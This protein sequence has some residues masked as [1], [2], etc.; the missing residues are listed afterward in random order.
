M[1]ELSAALQGRAVIIWGESRGILGGIK[2]FV[3][4]SRWKRCPMGK[5]H[6]VC[7]SEEILRKLEELTFIGNQGRRRK[8]HVLRILK[9]YF[10]I[11]SYFWWLS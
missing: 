6:W 5:A 11:D 1:A 7:V 8:H 9:E 3:E 10:L 2:H 4:W